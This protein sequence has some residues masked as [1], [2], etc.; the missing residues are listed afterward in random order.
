MGKQ[1]SAS[2]YRT[3]LGQIL[4]RALSEGSRL[5][6]EQDLATQFGA[7]RST[8]RKAIDQLRQDGLVISRQGDGNFVTGMDAAD[9]FPLRI[10]ADGSFDD[11]F[12][13]RRLLDG[14][15]AADAATN[16]DVVTLENMTR[17]NDVFESELSAS[18]VDMV[19]IRRADIEFHSAIA[20]A[21]S[22]RMLQDLIRG[23]APT[24]VPYWRAWMELEQVQQR[25]LVADTLFEHK[26]IHNAIEA[27]DPIIAEAAMRRHFQTNHT[28][29]ERLFDNVP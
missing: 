8:V 1:T 3:L 19:A 28:R 23:F 11:I 2:I 14:Q 16:R 6:V 17:S 13:L 25:K 9:T 24:V 10:D 5:P 18:E 4:N 27:G 22:N 15:A 21:S 7:S 26:M 29:Y 12:V 20:M